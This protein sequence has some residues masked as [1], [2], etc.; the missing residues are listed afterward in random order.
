MLWVGDVQHNGNDI[1]SVRSDVNSH[2]F[3][4]SMVDKICQ[5]PSQ[6]RNANMQIINK[7]IPQL[8][9]PSA[10]TQTLIVCFR[11][12]CF[13]FYSFNWILI[14]NLFFAEKQRQCCTLNANICISIY[15]ICCISY[16]SHRLDCG[17]YSHDQ[18][19]QIVNIWIARDSF[20]RCGFSYLY[21]TD[22]KMTIYSTM[23]QQW[24]PIYSHRFDGIPPNE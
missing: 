2:I 6:Y 17:L 9:S 20:L 24:F 19:A 16:S 5:N 11:V 4:F 18:R 22:E 7:F 14:E 8:K 1:I 12:L 13:L 23:A 3:A 21:R 10:A 15:S